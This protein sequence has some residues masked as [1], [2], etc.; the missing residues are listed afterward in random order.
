MPAANPL[1]FKFV[2]CKLSMRLTRSLFY[3]LLPPF[4]LL[5]TSFCCLFYL[6]LP[7]FYLLLPPFYL[8]LPPFTAFF[9]Y[10][11]LLLLPVSHFTAFL[12]TFYLL[13]PPLTAALVCINRSIAILSAVQLRVV[14]SF[15]LRTAIWFLC[16]GSSAY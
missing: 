8:L 16:I 7:P 9:I 3:L 6:L 10:F 5:F 2:Y 4:Y 15:H 11:Y 14:R 12:S 13:L 1:Q